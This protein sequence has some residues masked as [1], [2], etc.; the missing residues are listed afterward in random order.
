M[1]QQLKFSLIICFVLLCLSVFPVSLFAQ[2]AE[3]SP[4]AGYVWPGNF[5][6]VGDFKGSQVFGVRGGGYI[7]K[8]F[9]L[10]G[11]YYWNPHFQPRKANAAA[12]LAGD[13]GFPQGAV[14]ANVYDVEFTYHFGERS[15]FG[16]TV[17][18]YVVGAGGGL[19][20]NIKNE[21]AFVLNVRSV[22]TAAGVVF[23]PNDV[24]ESGDTFFTFSYGGGVKAT[25]LW[26][27]MG[28]FGDFRG[29]TVP[30]FLGHSN[31]WPEVNA[32]FVFSWGE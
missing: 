10:G 29:R 13:L 17:R 8:N 9:E 32:G 30:N 21:D 28:V 23:R 25:R 24:L 6:N 14:R 26:G 3:I 19:T 12:S 1:F 27:P 4:Y 31:T 18:P 5:S 2:T 7:T 11:N 22:P 16:S 15:L 20:T